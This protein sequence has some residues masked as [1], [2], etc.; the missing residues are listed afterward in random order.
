VSNE[1]KS[2]L[3]SARKVY[4]FLQNGLKI[5]QDFY[6]IFFPK[7]G[8]EKDYEKPFSLWEIFSEKSFTL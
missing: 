2:Q 4:R 5:N 6:K 3:C 1:K 7:K 8:G